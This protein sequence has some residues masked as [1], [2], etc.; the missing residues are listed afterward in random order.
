MMEYMEENRKLWDELTGINAAS[1]MYD[2]PSFKQ[3]RNSLDNL[4]LD[5]IGDV[6]GK[7]LLHLQCHFGMDTMSFA[8]LGA[9]VTGV[10]FS[11]KAIALAR[12]LAAE[13]AIPAR[14]VHCNVYDLP[15]HLEDRFDIVFSSYGFLCWL[16]DIQ[17]WAR[18]VARYVKPGG[19]FYM[20]EGHPF[21]AVF[22]NSPEVKDFHVR[23]SYFHS[24]A[25]THWEDESAY[26]DPEAVVGYPSYEWTHSLSDLINALLEADLKLMFMHEFPFGFYAHFPFMKS[27]GTGRWWPAV[28]RNTVPLLCSMKWTK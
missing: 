19:F 25:P 13:L 27:D 6:R 22:D 24:P 12:G 23:Y 9:D 7:R 15:D 14:F 28:K 11:A 20:A 5:E 21:T 2:L 10:D 4:V 18:I 17:S 8:R 26:A 16:P 1:G 3:G